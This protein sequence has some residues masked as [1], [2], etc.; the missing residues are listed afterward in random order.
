MAKPVVV[1]ARGTNGMR[2]QV[3]PDGDQQ[4]GYHINPYDPT[5]IA[6]GIK[7]VIAS[8]ENRKHMGEN[9]RQRVIQEFSWDI[10]TDRTL[11][12]YKEFTS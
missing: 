9:A 12:I 4:C 10:V 6:W 7:Q 1:G 3:I 5:D 11:Q 8:E 2:E